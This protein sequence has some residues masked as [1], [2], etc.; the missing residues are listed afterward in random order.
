VETRSRALIFSLTVGLLLFSGRA[1]THHGTNI[2]YDHSNP[3]RLNGVVTEFVWSNPHAQIYFDVEDDQGNVVHWGGELNSPFNLSRAGWNRNTLKPGAE[4]TLSVFPS[5]AGT[6]VG[7]V[8][9]SEP[10]YLDG[11]LV[12]GTGE[13]D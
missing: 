7:V 3:T 12:L 9:R 2:S 11:E 10:I 5:K 4:I 8:D 6:P 13:Q 1:F